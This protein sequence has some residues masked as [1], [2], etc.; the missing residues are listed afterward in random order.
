M[1]YDAI[2]YLKKIYENKTFPQINF[3]F[4][5]SAKK[6][7]KLYFLLIFIFQFSSKIMSKIHSLTNALKWNIINQ[8][9]QT[10]KWESTIDW[11]GR[12]SE[13]KKEI[14]FCV[15]FILPSSY[16]A[17]CTI[18]A[19]AECCDAETINKLRG[20]GKKEWKNESISF[21]AMYDLNGWFLGIMLICLWYWGFMDLQMSRLSLINRLFWV[22]DV[23]TRVLNLK[24]LKKIFEFTKDVKIWN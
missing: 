8:Q 15:V 17:C 6:K 1:L 13:P 2:L 10:R 3:Q 22:I 23:L 16:L 9:M 19:N 4:I 12:K 21:R 18:K 5:S 11:N 14:F 7:V 24:L 20:K